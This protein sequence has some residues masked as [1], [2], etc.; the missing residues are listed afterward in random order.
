VADDLVRKTEEAVD[1]VEVGGLGD[2]LQF[3]LLMG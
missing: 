2:D 1:V 3:F